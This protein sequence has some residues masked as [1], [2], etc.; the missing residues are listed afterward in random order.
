M[1]RRG[2]GGEGA[3]VAGGPRKTRARV[4]R[5]GV[6]T[7]ELAGV[8]R[9]VWLIVLAMAFVGIAGVLALRL[10]MSGGASEQASPPASVSLAAPAPAPPTRPPPK[11]ARPVRRAAPPPSAALEGEIPAEAPELPGFPEESASGPSGIA[12]YPPMGSDPP[13]RGILVPED[14]ELPEGYV[15]HYQATDEG[16]GLPA[17]L[18]FHPDYD[19]IGEDGEAI[20]LPEDRV[21][22]PELAPPGLPI[23]MLDLP[24]AASPPDPAP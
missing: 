1:M 17:I 14:F 10:A 7:V 13:K 6:R 23:R 19:W 8:R 3:L 20:D 15:R 4:D 2:C 12:L 9:G 21:V 24:A 16:E 5:D 11:P 18:M 22:P